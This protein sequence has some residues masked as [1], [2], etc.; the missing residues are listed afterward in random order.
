MAQPIR[1]LVADDHPLFLDGV[2]GSLRA[3]G[4]DVVGQA[5]GA[6]DLVALVRHHAPDLALIDVTMPG[7][8][9][10]AARRI[11][12]EHPN[13]RVVMLTVSED[14][15]TLLAAMRAGAAGYVL[16]GV[17]AAEMVGVVRSVAAAR[18]TSRRP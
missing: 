3:S 18:C 7:D 15:D 17:S 14:E 1:V 8:G 9:L 10:E 4:V 2:V 11:V 16:K 5:R 12:A 6:D 13:T